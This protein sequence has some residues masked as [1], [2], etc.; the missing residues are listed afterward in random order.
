MDADCK[1]L[2]NIQVMP[3]RPSHGTCAYAH[4]QEPASVDLCDLSEPELAI[5]SC[6]LRSMHLILINAYPG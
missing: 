5:D 3:V 2:I 6:I 4:V 1:D